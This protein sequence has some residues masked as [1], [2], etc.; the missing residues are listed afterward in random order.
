M[1]V[2]WICVRTCMPKCGCVCGGTCSNVD[3]CADMH[4]WAWMCVRTCMDE[5]RCVCRYACTSVDVCTDVH[6]WVWMCERTCM[7]ECGVYADV[8]VN[9]RK[10]LHGA[11]YN[12]CREDGWGT[13]DEMVYFRFS[14]TSQDWNS[15]NSIVRTKTFP[16]YNVFDYRYM[17]VGKCVG[18]CVCAYVCIPI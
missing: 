17:C 10:I 3:V 14:R 4:A 6:A 11:S 13:W 5:C 12:R 15:N 8:H 9:R 7:H 16:P 1:C 18:M 2:L